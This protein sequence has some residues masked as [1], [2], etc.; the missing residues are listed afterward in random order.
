MAKA[1]EI[2]RE[3]ERPAGA[4]PLGFGVVGLGT[5]SLACYAAEGESWRYFEIDPTVIRMSGN[6]ETAKFTFVKR[7]LP[8]LA[9][10]IGD[11]RLTLA[12][13]PDAGLDLLI[14]DAFS[15]DA[16]PMHLMTAEALQLYMQ[17]LSADGILV[18]HISNRYLDLESVVSSTVAKVPGLA[19]L[20]VEDNVDTDGYEALSS[21]VA[22]IAR[23]EAALEPFREMAQVRSLSPGRVHGW[24][25]DFSDILTP[26]LR[27]MHIAD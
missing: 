13:E 7:C 15:S 10:R 3:R 12:R 11:A 8:K 17:K 5:G 25:D 23:S 16:I 9:I 2:V 4:P 22:V 14:V 24:T 26:F 20:I 18:L 27:Q 21:T 1:I 19:G 6:S